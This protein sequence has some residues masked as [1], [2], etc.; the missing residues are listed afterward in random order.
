MR[1]CVRVREGMRVSEVSL[2]SICAEGPG[3]R[4]GAA[5]TR[6]HDMFWARGNS[7]RTYVHTVGGNVGNPYEHLGFVYQ[8][9]VEP[10]L[11]QVRTRGEPVLKASRT[12]QY[13]CV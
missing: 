3:D 10:A 4:G 1:T 9:Q 8:V 2:K 7:I 13:L 12:T 6:V 11:K 5:T